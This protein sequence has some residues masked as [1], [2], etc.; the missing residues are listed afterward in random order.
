MLALEK[1]KLLLLLSVAVVVLNVGRCPELLVNPRFFAEEGATY[2]SSAYQLSFIT[3]LF[4][5]HFGYYTLY[6]QLATSL[7]AL[8]PLEYA[9]LVTTLLSL[10]VQT[11]VSF[12]VL[13]GNFAFLDT[14]LRRACLAVV[15]PLISWPGHWLTIIG[16]Q[17]WF[18]AATFLVLLTA[19]RPLSRCRSAVTGSYLLV[20]G[21]TG[22][23]SCFLLPA[24]AWRAIREK[25]TEFF[26][27]TLILFFCLLIHTGVLLQ[28]LLAKSA[29]VACR[30]MPANLSTALGKTFVYQFAIPFTG[31]SLFEQQPF[32]SAGTAVKALL[33]AAFGIKLLIH[34]LFVIPLLAGM[35]V[36]IITLVVVWH[37]RGNLEVQLIAIALVIVT[38]LSN[39]CSINSVGGPRYYF[40]PSLMLLTLFIALIDLKRS[41]LIVCALVTLVCTTL[42]GNGYEYRSIMLKQAYHPAYPSWR[43]ELALWRAN[44]SYQL[45]IW[46]HPWKMSLAGQRP[47][48]S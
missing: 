33:E 7:A 32:V 8:V 12:F 39:I 28:A 1:R 36:M 6:N 35:A 3:N 17:C 43:A 31:R 11:G 19:A 13:W 27:Y 16:T 26:G 37:N 2:F 10:L 47:S 14:M 24:Y 15:I 42:L 48:M 46:P 21:L 22:V 44:P 30:F 23:V 20:A 25:S 40:L 34:N 41:R 4:S 9:P 45:N 5:A 29:D 38:I 18:G